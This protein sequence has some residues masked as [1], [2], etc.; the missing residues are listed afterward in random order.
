MT[1]TVR[2]HPDHVPADAPATDATRKAPAPLLP[3]GIRA[4]LFDLDGVLT[5][6]ARLHAAAWKEMF[7]AFLRARSRRTGEPCRLFA[8]PDD[9][10]AHVDGKLRQD[11][12]R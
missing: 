10:A 7:D 1:P 12:V 11:G 4:C 2:G 9:Y 5:Q 3:E 6:T 8:L